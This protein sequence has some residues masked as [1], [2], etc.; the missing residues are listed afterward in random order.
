MPTSRLSLLLAA[1]LALLAA[2]GLFQDEDT[3]IITGSGRVTSETRP[4]AGIDSVTLEG[5]GDVV[6]QEGAAEAL[7]I[8]AEDNLIPLITSEMQG[9]TLRLGFDRATWR[10]T[11]RPTQPIR[12]VLTVRDLR[13]FDLTGSGSFQANSLHSPSLT[14]RLSG[15]GDLTIEHL[16]SQSLEVRLEGTG[17]ITLAGQVNEQSVEITGSGQYQAGDLESQTARVTVSGTGDAVVWVQTDLAASLSGTGTINY[18]GAPSLSRRDI[19]GAGD[20]NP[21]GVK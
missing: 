20:I 16:D 21:M 6:V 13:A 1:A 17:N 7:T 8:E 12:F 9:A 10:D 19:S 14:L 2:C 3:R 4:V 15:T 5:L 11:L 18:W